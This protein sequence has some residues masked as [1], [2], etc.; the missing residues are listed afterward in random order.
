[1]TDGAPVFRSLRRNF[2]VRMIARESAMA[3][4]S[5]EAAKN[6]P[7]VASMLARACL[8][9]FRILTTVELRGNWLSVVI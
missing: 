3:D 4:G 5:S 2:S 1:G 9:M 7:E 8:G 6:A